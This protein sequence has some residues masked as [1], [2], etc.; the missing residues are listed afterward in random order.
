MRFG[1]QTNLPQQLFA[2]AQLR[3]YSPSLCWEKMRAIAFC[4]RVKRLPD[5]RCVLTVEVRQP[6][7]NWD[8]WRGSTFSLPYN[9]IAVVI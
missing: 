5:H 6:T 9:G 4:C 1:R 7:P 2:G 8:D 3:A